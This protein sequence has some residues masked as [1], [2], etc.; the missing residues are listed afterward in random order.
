MPFQ[1]RACGE[2][3][4]ELPMAFHA[5]MPQAWMEIPALE[6]AERGMLSS[7]QCEIDARRFFLRGLA[8]VPVHGL[9]K[10]LVWGVWVELAVEDY[11]RA[12]ELWDIEGR[13]AEPPAAG[14]L[15]TSLP[16][17]PETLGLS[18]QVVTRPVGERPLVRVLGGHP[19]GR[20]Q[21][22]GISQ[23]RLEE[24]WSVLLHEEG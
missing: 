19:L 15:A 7:D 3:H 10:P 2:V 24:L 6:E 23:A 4:D 12:C 5:E 22:E 14:V 9:G 11:D 16:L 18:V 8:E 17:Y 13:E 1:C 20:D 21:A